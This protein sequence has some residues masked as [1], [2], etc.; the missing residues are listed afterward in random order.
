MTGFAGCASRMP[1]LGCQTAI[2]KLLRLALLMTLLA[3]CFSARAGVMA[4]MEARSDV[5]E[6]PQLFA[7]GAPEDEDI[8][9]PTGPQLLDN[10]DSEGNEDQS[11]VPTLSA[12]SPWSAPA[13]ARARPAG[14][15]PAFGD[16]TAPIAAAP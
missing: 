15:R 9:S 3:L 4:A 16:R 5:W 7:A 10:D 2:V 6:A 1:S 8:V 14:V 13:A 11:L 12:L